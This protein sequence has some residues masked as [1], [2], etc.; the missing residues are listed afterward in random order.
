MKKLITVTMILV[1]LLPAAAL[2]D[3]SPALGMT[4]REY[5][6]KYNA[7]TAPLDSPYMKLSTPYSWTQ[8]NQYQVAWFHPTK[9]SSVIILLLSEDPNNTKNLDCGLDIVQICTE[10]DK[11]MLDL[12]CVTARGSEPFAGNLF[13]T[14]LGD[15]R[16]TQLLRYYFENGYKGTDGIAYY[17]LDE[18]YKNAIEFFMTS[19]WYYFE[20]CSMEDI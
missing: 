18:D 15:L 7:I 2:A 9:A 5:I 17:T 16:I 14:S 10:N 3:Y 19:G 13:G 11:D 4:M 20:I 8:F 1:L 6:D 12:I